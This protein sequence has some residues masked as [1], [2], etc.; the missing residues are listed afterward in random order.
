MRW[1]TSY[2]KDW[3]ETALRLR[4]EPVNQQLRLQRFP[5]DET[6]YAPNHPPKRFLGWQPATDKAVGA[7]SG[8]GFYFGEAL[9]AELKIPVGLIQSAIDATGIRGWTPGEKLRE[10]KGGSPTDDIYY[11]RQIRPIMPFAIRGVI[12]YQGEADTGKDPFGASYDRRLAALIAGW[13]ADWG[14]GDYP[15]IYIQLARIGFGAEQVHR[16]KLP[17]AEQRQIVAGWARVRDEQRR[18]LDAVPN[19]AMVVCYDLTTG[20]LHP[21]QKKPIGRRLALAAQ[22]IAYGRKIEYCGPLLA[23]AR[24]DGDRVVLNFTHAEGLATSD[25]AAVRQLEVRPAGADEFA[26]AKATIDGDRVLLDVG[27]LAG[28]LAIRYAY[29][30]WPDGNLVNGAHLPASPFLVEQVK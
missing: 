4:R 17:D 21:P 22:A 10:I 26:P 13:R 2:T 20:M 19:T 7:F 6:G 18:V 15:F 12:W 27:G 23:S 24:R 29:R 5:Q 11:Q 28:P 16:G 14:R 8:T 3:G 25:N 30:E 9:Q 1:G